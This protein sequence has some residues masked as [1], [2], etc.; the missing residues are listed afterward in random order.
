M[1]SLPDLETVERRATAAY[2]EMKLACGFDHVL[3]NHDGEGSENWDAFPFPVG[4]ARLTLLGFHALL[5]GRVPPH[6]ERWDDTL[7]P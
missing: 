1:L 3:P 2:G 6:A 7:L 4:D 5:D